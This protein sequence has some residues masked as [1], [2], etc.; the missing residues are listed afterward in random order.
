VEE[1]D[2]G[3]S[4]VTC[5]DGT[6]TTLV[7]PADGTSCSVAE[8]DDGSSTITC[9][10][11]TTTTLV[12]PADGTS[13]SVA[14]NDDGSSTITCSDGTRVTLSGGADGEACSVAQSGL[15]TC[16]DGSS[17]TL[18]EGPPGQSG[19]PGE[20]GLSCGLE[21]QA[22]GAI[23]LVCQD[24]SSAMVRPG[25][26]RHIILII[27]GGMEPANEIAASR[28]Y[29]GEDFALQ[30]H[31]FPYQA[32][33]TTWDVNSY[34]A[35]ATL[36]SKPAFNPATFDWT[37]GYD[38]ARGGQLPYPLQEDTATLQD[39]IFPY[40]NATSPSTDSAS[41]ATAM[42][43]GYKTDSGNI[44]WLPGD[45]VDGSIFTSMELLR[46]WRGMGIGVVS[47]VPF[48]HATPAAFISHN[49]SRS[50]YASIAHEIIIQTRPDVVI[51]GGHPTY[52]PGN[53]YISSSDLSYLESTTDY[54][55]VGRTD[56]VDGG[57]TL[58]AAAQLAAA[59]N[60]PLLGLFGG[61]GGGFE[62]PTVTHSPGSPTYQQG[63]DENPDLPEAAQAALT[64]LQTNANG[65]FLMIEQGEID[66]ANHNHDYK[67]MVA[68]VL[69]LNQT[70]Q[71]V[72][73]Y[74]NQPGDAIDW[75][76][77]TLVVTSDHTNGAL[78]FVSPL[79]LGEMPD[80]LSSYVNYK[81][82]GHTNEL[83]SLSVQG[84]GAGAFWRY[85]RNYP[86]A[87]LVDNTAIFR[88]VLDIG[89]GQ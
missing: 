7:L 39:Y 8:N 43:T 52:Y 25:N 18:L 69:E 68:L 28:Y 63:S 73:N 16:P 77:T 13:C 12:P 88:A 29:Y 35:Y 17:Y 78:R 45:P 36:A 89:L 76:N 42:A 41:A 2:D 48:S 22:D 10:D 67:S 81:A 26:R 64:R 53:T 3:S 79:G 1:N 54:V 11:G 19:T 61:S 80:D 4:T 66:W 83:V 6:T 82:N 60:L 84:C 74:V 27:G 46:A 47:S 33:V 65:F 59:G 50:N 75:S 70:V 37:V 71:A 23:L 30:H 24:G 87:V 62:T 5:S 20:N 21:E 57:Q 38:P 49:I 58:M 85:A 15:I 31:D 72:V 55:Y 51:G 32:Y 34:D 56:G 40:G 86:G 14:E 44:A 9:S